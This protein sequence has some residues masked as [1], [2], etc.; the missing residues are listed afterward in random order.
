MLS[1]IRDRPGP[2][3]AAPGCWLPRW[4]NCWCSPRMGPQYSNSSVP[5]RNSRHPVCRQVQNPRSKAHRPDI[6]WDGSILE[7]QKNLTFSTDRYLS[8]GYDGPYAMRLSGVSVAGTEEWEAAHRVQKNL[9]RNIPLPVCPPCA[10]RAR[11]RRRQLGHAGYDGPYAM[12]L[13]GVSVAGT[14]E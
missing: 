2:Y 10:A 4:R 6:S 7:A 12:R 11:Q 5:S 14:E 13:S 3:C 8:I 1:A 9:I